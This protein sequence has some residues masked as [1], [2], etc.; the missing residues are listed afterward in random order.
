MPLLS[1][2]RLQELWLRWQ[3]RLQLAHVVSLRPPLVLVR[4]S[5]WLA[6]LVLPAVLVLPL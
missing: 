1:P 3:R 4:M 6:L 5:G 2:R